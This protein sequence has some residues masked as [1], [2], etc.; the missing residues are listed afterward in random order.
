MSIG[1]RIARDVRMVRAW[2]RILPTVVR[3]RPDASYTMVDAFEEK[4]KPL[5]GIPRWS[6]KI[7]P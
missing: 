4:V 7:A 6:S 3:C 1:A 5:P 2:G